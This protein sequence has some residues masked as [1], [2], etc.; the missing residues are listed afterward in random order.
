M[1]K[2]TGFI[3]SLSAYLSLAPSVFAQAASSSFG[4]CPKDTSG[5]G[6]NALC[7]LDLGKLLP[8]L[9]TTIFILAITADLLYLI[10]GGFKWLTSGGDKAAVQAAREHIVAAIIGLILIFVSYVIMNILMNF[11]FGVGLSGT[12]TLPRV[13]T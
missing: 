11:F 3:L 12:Y 8:S 10:W 4:L 7:N 13:G 9:I 1:K 5:K 6:F 2:L